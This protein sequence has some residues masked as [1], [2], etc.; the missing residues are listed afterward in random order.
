MENK[1]EKE[2]VLYSVR[3]RLEALLKLFKIKE[4]REEIERAVERYSI[5]RTK[6]SLNE[7]S[8]TLDE[9]SLSYHEFEQ[10]KLE[11]LKAFHKDFHTYLDAPEFTGIRIYRKRGVLKIGSTIIFPVYFLNW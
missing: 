10:K 6:L 2:H 4:D 5:Y 9:L 3:T 7:S 8:A 1:N 11:V